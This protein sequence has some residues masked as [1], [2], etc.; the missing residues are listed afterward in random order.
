MKRH[1]L[2]SGRIAGAA[3]IAIVSA[4]SAAWAAETVGQGK[5]AWTVPSGARGAGQ[6]VKDGGTAGPLKGV[7]RLAPGAARAAGTPVVPSVGI[8][9]LKQKF[10][11]FAGDAQ[12][13]ESGAKNMQS[14]AK[15]CSEKAYTVQDQ[16]AA[17]CTGNETMNQ[18]MDK[19]Y[20]HCVQTFSYSGASIPVGGV[21]PITGTSKG[22]VKLPG[23]STKQFLQSV[24]TTASEARG[25]S[26]LLNLYANEVEQKGKALVP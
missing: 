25:L 24:G 22:G 20:K 13:Y 5:P 15:Q 4:G 8:E 10:T 11:K 1:G 21:D 26:Q 23:F 9:T 6:P 19:L 12:A 14:V 18:C 17:G 2:V 3:L 7:I 16:K